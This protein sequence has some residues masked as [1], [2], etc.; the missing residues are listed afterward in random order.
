MPSPPKPAPTMAM[1]TCLSAATG[2]GRLL[3]EPV[4][5]PAVALHEQPQALRVHADL[6]AVRVDGDRRLVE[7][8]DHQ[9]ARRLRRAVGDL[10]RTG[11]A[12]READGVAGLERGRL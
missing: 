1:S 10:V 12:A 4:V 7:R 2:A 8:R 6:V 9:D 5:D 11:G 3:V